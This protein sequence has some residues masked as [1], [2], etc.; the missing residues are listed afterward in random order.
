[1]LSYETKILTPTDDHLSEA[2]RLIRSGEVV[3]FP[4][5]TV[6]GLG[7]NAL[8][9]DAVTKIFKA[10][11]RP[12]DNPLIVHVKDAEALDRYG[13]EVSP[14]A[15]LLA[16]KFWPGPLT[17]IVKARENIS[18]VVTCG[19]DTVGLRCP[20]DPV[21]QS[22]IRESG[23]PIAA[24]SANLSGRPSPTTAQHVYQDLNTRIPLILDGGPC[25]VGVESTVLSVA[26]DQPI[27]FRP[28]IVG[29]EEIESVIGEIALS[30]AIRQQLPDSSK[31]QS[32]G[33]KYRH[34]APK[35]P[36]LVLNGTISRFVSYVNK[37]ARSDMGV[38]CFAGE[39]AFFPTGK[40]IALG[41][42]DNALSLSQNLFA[43]L[44]AFDEMK[45]SVIYARM[46]REDGAFLGVY[47]RLMKASGF[48]I[49]TV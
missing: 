8:D 25:S 5:E 31:V 29:R 21:A 34:Y 9:G 14:K 41:D 6:Y 42:G 18:P 23:Q 45:V 1:M 2:A 27:L 17:I 26:E 22:L 16:E 24:P 10:K 11:G 40:V 12:Q 33:M 20:V 38:L 28:G 3:A 15:R 7:A 44:R 46:C 19:L 13:R 49:I 47:N 43:A 37:H 4:T 35:C 32:P 48:H 36:L 39:E 30:P